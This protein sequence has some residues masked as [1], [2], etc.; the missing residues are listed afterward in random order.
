MKENEIRPRALFD[1]YLR[2]SLE[3]AR[4]MPRD[5]FVS[6]ACP[7]CSGQNAVLQIEKLGFQY[8]RCVDCGTLY[9][10]PRP[11]GSDL[12]QF[13]QQSKSSNFWA[14]EFFPAVAEPRREK[15]FRPKA[16]KV[17]EL[18]FSSDSIKSVC[19][20]GAGYGIFVEELKALKPDLRYAAVEPGAEL[21]AVCRSKGLEVLETMA[22]DALE[23]KG[24]F[25]LVICSEVIEHVFDPES[26]IRSLASLCAPGG[27]VLLTGL[28]Y[29]GFDILTLQEHSNSV[30]P[31]HHLNFI[32]VEGFRRLLQRC[33][34]TDVEITTPGQLDFDIVKNSQVENEFVRVL[35]S[36]GEE[37]Q[38]EFQAFL[39]KHRLSSHLWV[40]GTRK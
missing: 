17:S 1:E 4:E 20:V 14:K 16:Q 38:K 9:C 33:G 19:D 12:D 27:K 18:F 37:T 28:G 15:L 10:S 35:A 8:Q 29:E 5:R 34:L 23:W 26:F 32:S 25:D 13:Y 6:I 2:L 30:S 36:R 31:P 11:A 39:Q 7:A 22:E 3:D 40:W 21:A 24:R